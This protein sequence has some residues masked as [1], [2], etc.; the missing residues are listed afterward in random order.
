MIDMHD[1]P[2]AAKAVWI[3]CACMGAVA[4]LVS[5]MGVVHLPIDL[6]WQT[7]VGAVCAAAASF[8]HIKRPG[9]TDAFSA[10]ELFLFLILCL[11]GTA[12]AVLAVAFES[13]I[14]AYRVS[15]RWTSRLGTPAFSALGMGAAGLIY[16]ASLPA[17][18]GVGI[19]RAESTL[20]ALLLAASVYFCVHSFI[21]ETV[22]KLKAKQRVSVT[23]W[24]KYSLW[25]WIMMLVAALLAGLLVLTV[26][27]LGLAAL[28]IAAPTVLL[29][30]SSLHYYFG[31]VEANMLQLQTSQQH[32]KALAASEEKFHKAFDK[33]AIGLALIDEDLNMVQANEAFATITGEFTKKG[34]PR[35]VKQYLSVDSWR[36][37]NDEYT[38]W[39]QDASRPFTQE[40]HIACAQP[41]E[42]WVHAT[43]SVFETDAEGKRSLILQINDVT[44][45][46]QAEGRLQ[47]L[48]FHDPLTGL[49][50]R[51]YLQE[52]LSNAMALASR[53]HQYQYAV[54]MLDFNRFKM[55][56]DS[57]GHAAG[58]ELLVK[59]AERLRANVRDHDVVARF[60]G[61]EFAVLLQKISSDA[62]ALDLTQRLARSIAE[63]LTL[64]GMETSVTASFGVTFGRFGYTHA[65]HAL[66][67]ADLAMYE[68]K[69]ANNGQ[70]AVFSS[71]MHERV[72]RSVR[73]EADL[74]IAVKQQQFS[75]ALQPIWDYAANRSVGY[76]ALVRW[77]HP[78]EGVLMPG[79]FLA[80]AEE[81]GLIIEIGHWVAQSALSA[82]A[83]L[84]QST[85]AAGAAPACMAINVSPR[86]LADGEFVSWLMQH[87]RSLGIQPAQV[88][89]E[90]TERD[91]AEAKSHI[92]EQLRLLRTAGFGLALDDF[93]TG[94]SSISLLQNI[95]ATIIKLDRVFTQRLTG[96]QRDRDIATAIVALAHSLSMTVCAE[97]VE[98]VE[99]FE[100]LRALGCESVQGYYVGR[101][102]LWDGNMKTLASHG[103]DFDRLHPVAPATLFNLH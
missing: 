41:R 1:Y 40:L 21:I 52:A 84:N 70:A 80:V 15:K 86:Q 50:N 55:I 46:R 54:V 81:T 66:R 19:G 93:G 30:S 16:H 37:F 53:D 76:E 83:N 10:S 3:S 68:A 22:F 31:S 29:A 8:F 95:P 99:Q 4:F 23:D 7:L 58:D 91:L 42:C 100:A 17:L 59:I 13:F 18:S 26:D 61:D 87:A 69:R 6:L 5:L 47:F 33:A 97:G 32:L 96:A 9:T 14:G 12:A 49:K 60:G 63:P 73:I 57:L 75:L 102:W 38:R 82:L 90:L 67:D 89:I 94:Y 85:G 36:A 74:R 28:L 78:A 72:S 24:I 98:T 77:N 62:D 25:Q 79:S 39:R 101:P 2:P 56:N 51:A 71:A 44:A 65:D 43:V 88:I 103:P 92:L 45:R 34:V 48:A 20:L 27:R 35:S 11:A 64:A